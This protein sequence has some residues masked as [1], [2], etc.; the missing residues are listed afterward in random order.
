MTDTLSRYV[1]APLGELS[2]IESARL[3]RLDELAAYVRGRL[4]AG[5]P[6]QLVF[7]CTHNSRRS[8][9]AQLWAQT[10]AAWSGIKN[11]QTYSGGTEAT[12]FA[13]PAVA[14]MQRAGFLVERLDDEANPRY[15]VRWHEDAEAMV[16]FS[17]TFSHP[18]N[19]R[20]DFGAVMVCSD[21][22]KACPTVPGAAYRLSLP[23]VDPKAHD[24]QETEAKAYDERCAQIA[25]E[26]LYVFEQA[27]RE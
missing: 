27:A 4:D 13:P 6:V 3:A 26:L 24:G 1:E 18:A 7:I 5:E 14:A 9:M 19:P 2:A 8:H 25:R 20:R 11:V 16:C 15:A 23:Y 21:A 12:A 22:D 17:K 10:A